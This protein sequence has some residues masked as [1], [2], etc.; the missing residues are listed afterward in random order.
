MKVYGLY[1]SIEKLKL[2]VHFEVGFLMRNC[3]K[4]DGNNVGKDEAARI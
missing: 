4:N 3:G 2:L 1:G